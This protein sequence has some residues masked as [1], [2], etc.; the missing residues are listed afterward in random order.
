MIHFECQNPKSFISNN[1][2]LLCTLSQRQQFL[3][4]TSSHWYQTTWVLENLCPGNLCLSFQDTRI[5]G[6]HF[7]FTRKKLVFYEIFGRR[8]MAGGHLRLVAGDRP[9][10]VIPNHHPCTSNRRQPYPCMG[11]FLIIQ[12]TE[13]LDD[14]KFHDNLACLNVK[15]SLDLIILH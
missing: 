14:D 13:L 11:L 8:A 2:H 5:P 4:H 10:M 12:W 3:L 15:V 6:I 9:T 1:Q 7:L